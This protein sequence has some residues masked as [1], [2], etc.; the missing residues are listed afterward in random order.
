MLAEKFAQLTDAHEYLQ[1]EVIA[2]R[3]QISRLR[4]DRNERVADPLLEE[5]QELFDYWREKLAP[6]AKEFSG[7][8]LEAVLARLRP[9]PQNRPDEIRAAIDGVARLPYVTA[10][11]RAASGQT[12]ERQVEL[13]LICRS[14]AN[15]QR[16][17][18]YL[19]EDEPEPEPEQDGRRAA[20]ATWLTMR[21]RI[22]VEALPTWPHGVVYR[23]NGHA[24]T[25]CPRC[26]QEVVI[27]KHGERFRFDCRGGCR[28]GMVESRLSK[29]VFAELASTLDQAGPA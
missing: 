15:L 3:A 11:G 6:K 13:E 9:D 29:R 22:N 4:R 21:G 18:S 25:D 14:E 19:V 20:P 23:N 16:F 12:K 2:L 1:K 10:N 8:R 24:A 26:G 27:D 28:P 7:K 17:A 5:A